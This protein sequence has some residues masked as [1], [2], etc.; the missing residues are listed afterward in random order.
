MS[1]PIGKLVVISGF[2]VLAGY[3]T[4]EALESWSQ[5]PASTSIYSAPLREFEFPAITVCSE[6]KLKWI[7]I[8]NILTDQDKDGKIVSLFKVMP[9]RVKEMFLDQ[10]KTLARL[11]L[12]ERQEE[13][14]TSAMNETID[15]AITDI[16][17]VQAYRTKFV[18]AG[19]TGILT[20]LEKYLVILGVDRG[21]YIYHIAVL[22]INVNVDFSTNF[23]VPLA[24]GAF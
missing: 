18:N 23:D 9:F 19:W 15:I 16:D 22:L 21:K 12:E 2:L 3:F 8:L 20:Y 11:E 1:F 6:Y 24:K 13:G 17:G 5:S 14:D 10:I 4:N 7:G